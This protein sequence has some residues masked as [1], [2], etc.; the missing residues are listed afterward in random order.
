MNK[1]ASYPFF[2]AALL[3]A[4]FFV[5]PASA[6]TPAAGTLSES[7]REVSW[8]GGP[9]PSTQNA[10]CG[11]PANP[12]CDNFQ[13]T[14]QPPSF[15]FEVEI[16]LTP[17]GPD[18]YDMQVYGP[19]GGLTG[20]SGNPPG[21][22][23][24]VILSN[25]AGGTYTVAAAPFLV[26][27]AYSATA[28][29]IDTGEAPPPPPPPSNERPPTYSLH[30]APPGMADHAGEP[31]LGVNFK[32]D[33]V[34][35]I[36]WP[37]QFR[38]SF[39]QC[40]PARQEWEDVSFITISGNTNDPILFTDQ[41]LGRTLV[42]QLQFPTKQSLMA[43][44]DND[45]TD[46]L[47]SQGS[48]INCGVDHQGVGGGP[49]SEEGPLGPIGD[50]PNAFYYCAQDIA[51]AQCAVSLDGGFTFL[52]GVPIYTALDCGGLHGH[53]KVAPDGTVYVPNKSCGGLQ[54]VVASRDNGLTWSVRKVPGVTAGEWD[55]SVG[56]GAEGTVYM[57]FANGD[58]HPYVA[59]SR[60]GGL[61]WSDV[62][63]VG[64]AFG[65]KNTAFPAVIAG[66]DD[67][68]A[69]AFLGTSQAGNGGAD[70][71]NWPGVWHL[72][73]A[74]T[75]DGGR[76]WVTSNATPG[77]PVQRGTIFAGGFTPEGAQT[78]NLLDF[79]DATVDR[80]GRVL[81]AY[82]DGC[83]GSCVNGPPNSFLDKGAIARQVNGK[84]LFAAFDVAGV[85][86]APPVKAQ[87]LAAGGVRVT[88][89]EPDDHGSP[90]TAYHVRRR[91]EGGSAVVIATLGADARS[92]DDPAPPAGDVFY[93]VTAQ[94]A[95]GEG[96]TCNEASPTGA[97]P[98]PDPC[99]LPGVKLATDGSGDV[100]A[101]GGAAHDLLNVWV[102]EPAQA[103]GSSKLV[104]TTQVA[105]LSSMP[106]NSI[107]RTSFIAP[108]AV[109]C[110]TT[111]ASTTYFVDLNTN[112]P[113]AVGCRYG[114]LDGNINRSL[115][116]ADGCSFDQAAG[117]I[118][119]TIANSKVGNPQ[120]GQSIAGVTGRAE[121]LVGALGTGAL[122]TVDQAA[123]GSYTLSGNGSCTAGAPQ[124][125]DDA[126]STQEGR[127]VNI[128]VL[129]NDSDPDGEPLT[130]QS[131]G[132][133]ANGGVANNGDGTLTYAP[134]AG[135]SG[136]DRFTYTIA[137]PGGL[138]DTADVTVTVNPKCPPT[139]TGSF[140]DDFEPAAEAGW[141]MVT[142]EN[143]LGPAS[144]TWAVVSDSQAHS[145]SRSFFSDA[146]TIEVKDDYL[147]APAADLSTGSQLV[148]WH[149]FGFEAGDPGEGFDG[150]VLEVSTDGGGSWEDVVEGGGSF[151]EGGYN[152]TIAGNF[153]SPI[154][155]RP[156]WSG[157][158]AAP[159]RVVVNLGAFAG[160]DVLVRWRLATDQVAIGAVPGE[161][162]WVDDVQ[163]TALLEP[164]TSCNEPPVAQD[165][166]ATTPFETPV[167]VDV[168]AN[169]SDPDGDPLAVDST[170]P[171][172]HGS[173][174]NNGGSVTYTPAAG[175]S[176]TDSFGYTAT[177]GNG[178]T[179]S[180]T[181]TVTVNEP[182]NRAPV[183]AGDSATT[184]ENKPV[185]VN[186]LANDSDPDGDPLSIVAIG[187]AV[188]GKVVAK[189]NGNVS[190]KPNQ[191]FTGTD[192]F[193][194]TISDG[195]G[196]TATATVTVTV[197]PR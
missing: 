55:P 28:R 96:A 15:G 77:D 102:A 171:A 17:F 161:G 158:Q 32:T 42:S 18:D 36:A 83:T 89:S 178:G 64:T 141:Q 162:W 181:V 26:N 188:H 76:T 187:P 114:C 104:F 58:G 129:A 135:F 40:S 103:D 183:A 144:P 145:P 34:M 140:A 48:G 46:W 170:T 30:V 99:E 165:D 61:T 3:A 79:M 4:A 109:V 126:V 94:N 6:A 149:R 132:Q 146:T 54:A 117:T 127:P 44:T 133:P 74:H 90:I 151:V 168:L 112:N 82:A 52:A 143:V 16:V 10:D 147:I 111:P 81:V 105:D 192:S 113:T 5:Y 35:Y 121:I 31:T 72:Y 88:W 84:R 70:D 85:P 107:W 189:K 122:V 123:G 29:L 116:A 78:R 23:E 164:A 176:G 139:P 152:A 95:H 51:L 60:D 118:T 138:T 125:N 119:V 110:G 69:F 68:A 56:I 2:A 172:G 197:T 186:V 179:A 153:G 137:D 173:V 98:D 1:H 174:A 101:P 67:R 87:Q 163:F 108:N 193:T 175:F 160:N 47:P 62:Q 22:P 12:A 13:L 63:D 156:A 150:G 19:D 73:V 9:K 57:G 65:I 91:T 166:A 124:A 43:I 45:G 106:L 21:L 115:G 177:D 50:Y 71:P 142:A 185:S 184:P 80:E 136:T 195:H 191:G 38:V 97:E 130:I 20:N 154:A 131:V 148:F 24:T 25:P 14:I 53:P 93:S 128:A 66:D 86:E 59:V 194:Y 100:A 33:K 37:E 196:H 169:D 27:S 8:T 190:Y 7:S 120:A 92:H 182:G 159:A 134:A 180:A 167:T 157:S 75:Y 41:E 11:G 39:D 49:F 155:G